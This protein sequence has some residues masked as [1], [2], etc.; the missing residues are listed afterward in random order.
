MDADSDPQFYAELERKFR[1]RMPPAVW[2]AFIT[3]A[4]A[5][6][7]SKDLDVVKACEVPD[8]AHL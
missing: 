8:D 4:G 1:D 5:I 7:G 3:H 6:E 2:E